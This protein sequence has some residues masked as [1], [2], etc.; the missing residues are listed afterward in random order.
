MA[1]S[2]EGLKH[3]S[4]SLYP[5]TKSLGTWNG[6]RLNLI[7]RAK[8]WALAGISSVQSLPHVQLSESPW[9]AAHRASLSITNFRNLL[10][11]MSIESV[12]PSNH[13]VLCLPLLLLFNLS[14]HQGIFQWVGSSHQVDKAFGV[15]ASSSVLPMNIQDWFPLG[16]TG[17]ITLQSQ[18]SSPTPQFKSINSLA[19]SFL[20]SP[21]LT[22]IHY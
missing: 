10:K 3:L 2:P 14:Q 1:R 15:L 4:M 8:D 5:E 16:W 6:K 13:L 20:Y 12:M 9:T 7:A 17:W 11:H 22:S 18:E 19:L 21:T